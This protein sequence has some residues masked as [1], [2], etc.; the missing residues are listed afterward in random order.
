[1][2]STSSTQLIS[3]GDGPS[4]GALAVGDV[5]E[6]KYRLLAL[7]GEG[8]MGAV[9]DAENVLIGRR[10]AIKVLLAHAAGNADIVGRF[11]QEARAAAAVGNEH[12]IDV[13]DLGKLPSGVPYIVM[14]RLEGR[15]LDA[16]VTRDGRLPIARA[17]RILI[18]VC[19]ALGA[20]HAKGIVHRD[21][22][23]AN[24][25]LVRRGGDAD[26]VKVLDFGI[27]KVRGLSTLTPSAPTQTGL[28]MGTP[29]YMSP[30]QAQGKSDVDHRSDLY[31]LGVIFYELLTG[32]VPFG[33]DNIA[34]VLT[35]ILRDTPPPPSKHRPELPRY[36]DDLVLRLLAKEP[37]ERM[38]SCDELAAA[39]A[40]LAEQDDALVPRGT[41]TPV[42][43]ANETLPVVAA[44]ETL[45]AEPAVGPLLTQP[46]VATAGAPVG[47][48]RAV[49]AA[50]IERPRALRWALV[51]VV[52]AA[53]AI[54]VIVATRGSSKAPARPESPSTTARVGATGVD[55]GRIVAPPVPVPDAARGSDSTAVRAEVRLQITIEPADA[56]LYLGGVRY[57]SPVDARQARSLEPT[58]VVVERPGYKPLEDLIILDQ[59]IERRYVLEK[60][61]AGSGSARRPGTG[62]G[63][64]PGAGSGDKPPSNAGS[65]SA[66]KP[67]DDGV[68]RGTTGT[69]RGWGS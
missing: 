22:K 46:A 18:Q 43:G 62:S 45:T 50:T 64:K 42:P 4:G 32:Q 31:A 26:F 38:A 35:Q 17:A 13:L 16:V 28:A 8:G 15:D 52:A 66:S 9:W 12:I 1:V 60:L 59:D 49:V 25:F 23:P 11:I 33:G 24:I 10:V 14:E 7:L 2:A 63:G 40:P 37:G 27:S 41:W 57:P 34:L 65:G 55:A 29:H 53:L 3:S 47:D 20:A 36:C 5:L 48:T 21:L 6:G 69:I 68:Y 58:R 19:D 39:L 61:G 30:E 44:S 54:V 56:V 67:P 51:A